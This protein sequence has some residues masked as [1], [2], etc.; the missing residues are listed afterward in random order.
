[1][2]TDISSVHNSTF[3]RASQ[4]TARPALMVR[5]PNCG[6]MTRADCCWSTVRVDAGIFFNNETDELI[7]PNHNADD[8][9]SLA[10]H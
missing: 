5:H 9:A 7:Y 3:D 1:M 4:P 2:T 10:L 8:C 6:L